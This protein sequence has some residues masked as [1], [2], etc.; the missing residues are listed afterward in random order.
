MKN[1]VIVFVSILT[2]TVSLADVITTA[3]GGGAD[4]YI[5]SNNP[6]ANYGTGENIVLKDIS[7]G[8]ARKGYMRFDIS[9]LNSVANDAT[10]KLVGSLSGTANADFIVGIYG[11]V[12]SVDIDDWNETVVN[13]YGAPANA[14]GNDFNV[15]ATFLG[16]LTVPQNL[17]AGTVLEFTNQSLID[18]IN[19]DTDGLITI[20]VNLTTTANFQLLIATKESTSYTAPALEIEAVEGWTVN[21]NNPASPLSVVI[22]N[23]IIDVLDN[24]GP[25][26]VGGITPDDYTVTL[27]STALEGDYTVLNCRADYGG[28][29]SEYSLKFKSL[30]AYSMEMIVE[31]EAN[32]IQKFTCGNIAGTADAFKQFYTGQRE[33]ELFPLTGNVPPVLYWSSKDV[34]FH[35]FI[36]QD[37]SNGSGLSHSLKPKESGNFLVANPPISSDVNY[38]TLSDGS[39]VQP[40]KERYVFRFS[41]NLWDV[42]QP[43]DNQPSQYRY[44]LADMLMFDQWGGTGF[45]YG[46]FV[47]QWLRDVTGGKMKFLT[48]CQNWS[49]LSKSEAAPDFYRSED[50]NYPNLPLGTKEELLE[51]LDLGRQYGRMALYT[52][53]ISTEDNSWSLAE[54]AIQRA[55]NTDGTPAWYTDLSTVMPLVEQQETDIDTDLNPS[56]SFHDQSASGLVVNY[57]VSTSNAGTMSGARSFI[58]DVCQYSK[59][60]HNG[61]VVSESLVTEYLLGDYVDGGD[62]G[63]K[64]GYG[65]FDFSPEYKLRRLHNLL[66][67]HSMGLGYRYF[68]GSWESPDWIEDGSM[69]YFNSDE[70]LDSYRASEILYGNGAYLYSAAKNRYSLRKV[71]A[72]TECFT[73]GI[74]Q[75]YYL[76]QAVDYVMYGNGGNWKYLE[77]IVASSNSR[78]DM[79][80]WYKQFHIRYA[81]G[82]HVF[83]NRG[84]A[85]IDVTLPDATFVTLPENGWAV[86]SEDGNVIGYTALAGSDRVDF[87]EDKNRNI[88]YVNPR[89]ATSYLG[90]EKPTVWFDG[91]IHCQLDE[92]D[93][94]LLYAYR[95]TT[96]NI[97]N[98]SKG[99]VVS[100][101]ETGETAPM[102]IDVSGV[103]NTTLH[104]SSNSQEVYTYLVSSA[105]ETVFGQPSQYDAKNRITGDPN[106]FPADV[107][108]LKGLAIVPMKSSSYGQEYIASRHNQEL[109]RTIWGYPND[110]NEMLWERTGNAYSTYT[111][112][113][114]TAADRSSWD[115]GIWTS[116]SPEEGGGAVYKYPS[117]PFAGKD[118]YLATFDIG[119]PLTAV[120]VGVENDLW[121]LCSDKEVL[122][123]SSIDGSLIDS[124]YISEQIDSPSGMVYDPRGRLWVTDS[125]ADRVYQVAITN[126]A[127]LVSDFN[128]DSQVN[129]K[130]FSLLASQWLNG[131]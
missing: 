50:Y 97:S 95:K 129:L 83:V 33:T 103:S 4:T 125:Q 13:W 38:A 62:F 101:F 61:P 48:L 119:K 110:P 109:Y 71:H 15:N 104:I 127:Y 81:N 114:I 112:G 68:Y 63:I 21:S 105:F 57:D 27:V 35:G 76:L 31:G 72:L 130:D 29:S 54:G 9:S 28:F 100:Y 23:T 87:C 69:A 102:G 93:Q 91:S 73:V 84:T 37:Y 126:N 122:N 128:K 118:N 121:I 120:S 39:T 14:S 85:N 26:F 46:K 45:K 99:Q 75:K 32:V 1:I 42:Y 108:V 19:S 116:Y 117:T 60:K 92:P 34:F 111:S 44:E 12:D 80:S 5:A 52:N 3:T 70:S 40:L 17:S 113:D 79:L 82:L 107:S 41:E 51:Y 124:F 6:A 22:D 90:V 11:V 66:V 10:L 20:A 47:L 55:L 18:F 58:K 53:Y 16:N 88:M 59:T 67:C 49:T 96:E 98:H 74:L 89:T 106:D 94:T 115:S 64:G 43:L 78:E 7:Q 25:V 36:D 123:I 30:D 8:I 86:Y 24:V 56:A 2:A 131:N 77:E 65:R